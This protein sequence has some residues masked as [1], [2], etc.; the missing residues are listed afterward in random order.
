MKLSIIIC[1]YNTDEKFLSECLFSIFHST[2]KACEFEVIVI[3]DGSDTD[4]SAI[5]SAYPVRYERRQRGGTLSARLF[6]IRLAK[7]EYISFVDSDDTV[8]FNYHLPMLCVAERGYDIVVGGWAFHTRGTR[9]FCAADPINLGKLESEKPLHDFLKQQGR[10]HSAYVLWNKVFKASLLK[11]A[12]KSVEALGA[13]H[14]FCF[15]EDALISFFAFKEAK[16]VCSVRGGFYFYRIHGAQSVS[17]DSKG[18]L[19]NHIDQMSFTLDAMRREVSGDI[20]LSGFV[21]GWSNLMARSHFAYAKALG[22]KEIYPYIREKYHTDEL[23]MPTACDTEAYGKV[24][25]LPEN[26]EEIE[27][28]L[29]SDY[30]SGGIIK[31][32]RHRKKGYA[33]LCADSLKAIGATVEYRRAYGGVP[34]ERYS[35]LKRIIFSSPVYKIGN[36]IFKKGSKIRSFLKR[37]I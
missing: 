29:L 26:T 8:S 14:P 28:A 30:L 3:D 2:V 35:I 23:S 1:L 31:L 6:G 32:G 18:R 16:R 37:F 33:R 17:V 27:A 34:R 25:L 20:E 15:A 10:L 36:R 22:F 13:P 24:R 7:G 9:Y 21:E 11:S 4:Y 19:L 12:L 5:L